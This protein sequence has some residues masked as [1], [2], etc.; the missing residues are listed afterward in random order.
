MWFVLFAGIAVGVG[1]YIYTNIVAIAADIP[2]DKEG[3]ITYHSLVFF[4]VPV[5][6]VAWLLRLIS[7]FVSTSLQLRDDARHRDAMLKTYL[8][9]VGNKDSKVDEKDRLVMLTAIFRPLPG[10][11]SE[12]VAPPSIMDLVKTK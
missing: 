6:A 9:L 10:A 8:A 12:D 3:V 11:Q 7:R 5:V 1:A 2:K 4:I